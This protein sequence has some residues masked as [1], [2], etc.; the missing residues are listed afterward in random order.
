[1]LWLETLRI[2]SRFQC[3]FSSSWHSNANVATLPLLLLQCA[4]YFAL[5][6][7]FPPTADAYAAT[8]GT[9]KSARDVVVFPQKRHPLSN[10]WTNVPYGVCLFLRRYIDGTERIGRSAKRPKCISNL[11]NT[12]MYCRCKTN[13]G[14]WP[15]T[16]FPYELSNDNTGRIG[17]THREA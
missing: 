5:R 17:N 3:W 15:A 7:R 1:M 8:S 11:I 10:L 16:R 13:N 2:A 14:S 12:L 4:K 9:L 6:D